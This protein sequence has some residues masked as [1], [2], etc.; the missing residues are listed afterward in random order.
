MLTFCNR[1]INK[2]QGSQDKLSGTY[3]AVHENEVLKE[4]QMKFNEPG[5]DLR[6]GNVKVSPLFA[7]VHMSEPTTT[8]PT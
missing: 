5:K 3:K 6:K 7:P 8:W 1:H 2:Q 4:G